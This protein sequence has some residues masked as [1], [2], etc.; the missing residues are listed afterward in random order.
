M[1]HDKFFHKFYDFCSDFTDLINDSMEGVFVNYT[2]KMILVTMVALMAV[3]ALRVLVII[4]PMLLALIVGINS[5]RG[6][7]CWL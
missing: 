1:H 5:R 7:R 6:L 2:F 4:M 3:V